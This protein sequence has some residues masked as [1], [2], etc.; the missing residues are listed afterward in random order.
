MSAR[1]PDTRTLIAELRDELQRKDKII[2]V[3]M[4]RVERGMDGQGTDYSF[5]QT[6]IL[7][8]EQ[9]KQRTTELGDAMR[10]LRAL[11]A[12]LG[13]E[14]AAVEAARARLDAA[15][16]SSSDGFAMFDEDDR[17]VL[18]NP[19]LSEVVGLDPA[20]L[21]QGR[22]FDEVLAAHR[23]LDWAQHWQALHA[24]AR[25]GTPV[26]G[27]LQVGD[28]RWVRIAE[29]PSEAG[30]VVGAYTDISDIKQRESLRRQ[31]D[32][33]RQAALLRSTLDNLEQGVAVLDAKLCLSAW[34]SRLSE[35]LGIPATSLKVGLPCRELPCIGSTAETLTVGDRAV[36]GSDTNVE[37]SLDDGRVLDLHCGAM[38]DQGRVLTVTEI[39]EKRL[40]EAR[41]R[42][43]L[44]ELR[45]IFE[46][47]H[48]AI[49]YVR[50]RNFVN[51]NSRMAEMFGWSDAAAL[52]G[53]HTAV[54]YPSEE[55][56][57][58]EGSLIYGDLREQGYSDRISQH[59]RKDGS[60]IWCHRTGRPLD[61]EDPHAGSIWVFVD[62]TERRAQEERLELAHKVFHHSSD[63]LLV[64]DAHGIIM[65]VNEAFT[66]I[67]GYSADEAIGNSPRILKSGR[68]DESF[69]KSMWGQLLE[70]GQWQ[71]ELWDRR[72]DGEVYPKWLSIAAVR[73]AAGELTNFVASFTDITDRK[74]A[75]ARIQALAEHDHLTGLPNRMLLRDRFAH[76]VEGMRRS[77]KSLAFMFVD[78]DHFKRI[79]DSLGHRMGDELLVSVVKR[80]RS[81]LREADTI[82]REGGDE[83]VVLLSDVESIQAAASIA[84]K[85]ISVLAN[86][87]NLR[88]MPITTSASIGIAMAPADGRDFDTLLQ[89]AD[90]AM[91]RS[92]EIGRGA[93]TFFRQEMNDTAIRRLD[94]VNALHRAISEG[95]FELHYQ[96]LMRIP[97]RRVYGAEALLR[98]SPDGQRVPAAELIA[99]AEES[100]LILP[101]GD[102]VMANACRQAR[103][104]RDAGLPCQIAVNVSGIQ[105]YR[106]N[107]ADLLLRCAREAAI[108]PSLIEIELTESTLIQDSAAVREVI[109]DVKRLGS[110][111]AIDDFGTGYSSLSYL[112]RFRVDKLKIDRSFIA[113]AQGSE[114]DRAIVQMIA[115]ISRLLG[116]RCLAEGVENEAQFAFA[117]ASG[118]HDAQG[119]HIARPLSVA[120][121]ERFVANDRLANADH[122][123]AH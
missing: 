94:M 121:Y 56:W 12:E 19:Q 81:V 58:E 34:N 18:V 72:K 55:Y 69:Y 10:S 110:T 6:A 23:D 67:S 107:V 122:P 92:K 5:F 78:L 64:T 103:I 120:D 51:C 104:W 49:A 9:V 85:I 57:S 26:R 88:G 45:L 30:G 115:N 39:T 96:P 82:S 25:E 7:L 21:R 70:K 112:S 50:G 36:A 44:D 117:E 24:A 42:R 101:I 53:Q 32:L 99:L 87:F 41:I 80:L 86:P 75:E 102:W 1:V 14:R 65:D 54:I 28:G 97:D 29:Q 47:A 113:N 68:Q 60:T 89:K 40:Q 108:E 2:R 84:D 119:Y 74:R 90:T 76:A 71:G 62:L 31:R 111:V 3:L 105:I 116:M 91:Y 11:N 17:L 100:G 38:P 106:A 118:C 123:A 13:Q 20:E 114:E 22:P 83:F 66:R 93:Y 46:N 77:G 63:A 35:I 27:E 61:Q 15:I 52:I 43:L 109:E 4:D 33:S 16:A 8:G 73:N 79:N 37:R 48:V 98:W 59:M 95:S